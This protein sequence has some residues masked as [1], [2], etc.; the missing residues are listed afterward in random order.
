MYYSNL[1]N[2]GAVPG[3]CVD[4]MQIPSPIP[5][6]LNGDDEVGRFDLALLLGAWGLNPGHAA[7]LDEGGD[8]KGSAGESHPASA[9]A[10]EAVGGD[11]VAL[12]AGEAVVHAHDQLGGARWGAEFRLGGMAL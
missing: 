9:V 1:V 4:V 10:G 6:D 8:P 3:L 7:D 5:A 11:G 2:D 12:M